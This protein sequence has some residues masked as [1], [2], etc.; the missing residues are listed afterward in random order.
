MAF[1]IFFLI[2]AMSFSYYQILELPTDASD[3][4]IRKAYKR[5]AK[6][7]HPDV[8]ASSKAAAEFVALREAFETLID[9]NK[10]FTYD[11]AHNAIVGARNV[12]QYIKGAKQYS[13]MPNYEQWIAI[14]KEKLKKQREEDVTRFA[15]RRQNIQQSRFFI[16]L[17]AI[18]YLKITAIYLMAILL[19]IAGVW[20][21]FETHLLF[22][23]FV[24]P[25]LC[26]SMFGIIWARTLYQSDI[27]LF[28]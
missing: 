23:F 1:V 4:D 6:L 19:F 16:W 24:L 11:A 21:V 20:I 8:N 5:K 13:F 28:K 17:N 7:L 18:F 27:K 9:P 26:A 15:E 14:K 2:L 22:I 3:I 12:S 10:R 25:M